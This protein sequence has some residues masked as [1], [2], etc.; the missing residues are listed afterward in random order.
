MAEN[1]KQEEAYRSITK[2]TAIFGSTQVMSMAANIIKGK[3]AAHIV[4]AYG[5][6]ISAHLYSTATPIQQLFTCGLNISAVKE[7]SSA[8]DDQERSECITY[9]RRTI[10]FLS[11]MAFISTAIS[12][13]WLSQLTFGTT[14]HW[15]WFIYI[16]I[17]V[18]FLI[19]TSGETTILQGFRQ[20]KNL[21][22]CNLVAPAVGLTV[23]IPL[24]WLFG[25]EGIA[26]SIA[27]LGMASWMAA[28][29]FTRRLKI[30]H[31]QMSWKDVW[32]KG[33]KTITLG[34]SIMGS[35]IAGSLATY[36]INT[37]ISTMG[38][39]TDLGLYQASTSI[40]LQCTSMVFSAMATDYFPHLSSIA[41]VKSKAQDLV[42]KEG[43]IAML[44]IVPIILMLITIAPV[45][46]RVLLTSE[47]DVSIF[48]LR[49]MS[50]CLL[51]RT[52]CFPLDYI[53]I[54]NGD[55]KF[56]LLVEGVWS[57]IKTLV[58]VIAGYAIGKLDGIGVA[59]IIGAA[60]D[61]AISIIAN[62]WR[63]GIS[64]SAQYYKTTSVLTLAAA[65]CFAAS[66]WPDIFV[67]YLTMSLITISTCIFSYQQ[68]DKRID[69]KTIIKNR[70]RHGKS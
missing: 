62:K 9:F 25:I 22:T 44:I 4:G 45:V 8:K 42:S 28:K 10:M 17:A 66:L 63:Y 30:T 15:M 6:G 68:I 26:P 70:L 1:K 37:C 41:K 59:L 61:I 57:N 39:E 13:W 49:A 19:L 12:A 69:I 65:A 56:F 21:A 36:A 54:A 43:E 40:T 46:I 20:L 33:R 2:S 51:S 52:L 29:L 7:I 32:L 16:A 48:L 50:L 67:S 35:T 14:E 53:C 27:I 5:L 60:I 64:Y 23:A 55:N 18:L 38:S 34:A 24:Y 11:I 58:L 31:C 47:F 3:L